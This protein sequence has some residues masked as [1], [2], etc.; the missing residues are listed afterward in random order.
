MSSDVLLVDDEPICR[1]PIARLLRLEGMAVT[2][3]AD[4]IEALR[5]M[6]ASRP[7]MVL[8]DLTLPRLSGLDVLRVIRR[9]EEFRELPVIVLTGSTDPAD[10]RCAALLGVS[11]YVLKPTFSFDDL[12]ARIRR[13]GPPGRRPE[14]AGPSPP[15]GT[16]AAEQK[17]VAAAAR[18]SPP[19]PAATAGV[20]GTPAE[21]SPAPP[22]PPAPSTAAPAAKAA[23]LLTRDEVLERVGQCAQSKTL[24]G[25]VSQVVTIA[26]SPRGT[27]AEL[28]SLLKQDVVLATRV[29]QV[30]NTAKYAHNKPRIATVEEAVRNIGVSTVRHIALSA[31]VFEAFPSDARDG[32]NLVRCWQHSLAVSELLDRLLAGVE[33]IEPGLAHLVGLCHDL[34][35]VVLRQCLVEQYD[36]LALAGDAAGTV[37]HQVESAAFGIA[38][39]E[40]VERILTQLGLPAAIVTP[41]R[42]YADRRPATRPAGRLA[43][44]LALADQ[45]AHGLQLASS[46]RAAVGPIGVAEYRA[47]RGGGADATPVE[48]DGESLRAGVSASTCLLARLS[49]AQ[50]AE[51]AKPLVAA[52]P[53][54]VFYARHAA[55]SAFDPLEA[56]LRTLAAAVTVHDRLPLPAEADG[57]DLLVVAAPKAG[58]AGLAVTD[59][60]R[61][62]AAAGDAKRLLYLTGADAADVPVTTAVVRRYPIPLVELGELVQGSDT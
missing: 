3:A 21:P 43:A 31:G 8:L 40:L 19:P 56:A 55:L 48:I 30:A 28:V 24:A 23:K 35:E 17:R 36:E 29:L 41:V 51:L 1:E 47:A 60:E 26:S 42:E 5:T 54:R 12:L 4:G 7:G 49:R 44:A 15:A 61:A 46:P 2:C 39:P 10:M 20:P 18:R 6:R 32:F 52:A 13:A 16:S 9:S 27:V 22:P 45:Y 58:I 37:T 33:G 25:V 14:A 38:Y 53:V 62:V 57:Y 59:A 11:D 34:G 50:E